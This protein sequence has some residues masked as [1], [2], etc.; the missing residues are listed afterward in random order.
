[1]K[2]DRGLVGVI[3]IALVLSTLVTLFVI[4]ERGG[5]YSIVKSEYRSAGRSRWLVGLTLLVKEPIGSLKLSYFCLID[6]TDLI[7][8]IDREGTPEEVCR[9]IPNLK[10]YLEMAEQGGQDPEISSSPIEVPIWMDEDVLVK[11]E[12]DLHLFD[13]SKMVWQAVPKDLM[14]STE[15]PKFGRGH[16]WDYYSV[17]ACLFDESGNLTRFYEGVADFYCN[18]VIIIE[19]LTIQM[20]EEKSVYY[21]VTQEGE[22]KEGESVLYAPDRGVICFEDINRNARMT[23]VYSLDS[24]KLP[25]ITGLRSISMNSIVHFVKIGVNEGEPEYLVN[26]LA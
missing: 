1:M 10:A 7:G 25:S 12:F 26:I 3:A 16:L 23:V 21:G 24:S 4:G 17:F 9:R 11:K 14:C 5:P 2:A 13:F 8:E 22:G 20:N 6:R 15:R 18:K 19:E